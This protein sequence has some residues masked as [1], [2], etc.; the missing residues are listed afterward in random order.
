MK[1]TLQEGLEEKEKPF[2]EDEQEEPEDADTL[3]KRPKTMD[4][5]HRLLLRNTKPL[6]Q[7]RNAAVSS[8][9]CFSL[10]SKFRFFY[11]FQNDFMEIDTFQ[12][13]AYLLKENSFTQVV[14][15]VA[16]LYQHIAPRAEVSQVAR[17]LVRLLRSHREVQAVVLTNIASMSTRRKVS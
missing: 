4:P 10:F 15:A 11:Y 8:S 2:Y 5:D 14:L 7:S 16:Q 17:A 1:Y 6:L 13:L 3:S 12:L 9:I